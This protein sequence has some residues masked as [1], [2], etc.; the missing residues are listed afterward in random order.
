MQDNFLLSWQ[1][2]I[3]VLFL[4]INCRSFGNIKRLVHWYLKNYSEKTT[5]TCLK[6]LILNILLSNVKLSLACR[7]PVSKYSFIV[8]SSAPQ[9]T[10]WVKTVSVNGLLTLD[11]GN[12]SKGALF[13]VGSIKKLYLK[14]LRLPLQIF[15]ISRGR[16]GGGGVTCYLMYCLAYIYLSCL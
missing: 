11:S 12:Y 1:L 2:L 6:N 14:F 3:G 4:L 16:R 15:R 9:K 5:M 7:P 10:T 13:F 8:L